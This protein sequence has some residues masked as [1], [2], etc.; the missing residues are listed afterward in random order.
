MSA[1]GE[2]EAKGSGGAESTATITPAQ[3]LDCLAADN[4]DRL[5]TLLASHDGQMFLNNTRFYGFAYVMSS[6]TLLHQ[7]CTLGAVKCIDTLIRLGAD[8]WITSTVFGTAM[9]TGNT[10]MDFCSSPSVQE[11]LVASIQCHLDPLW[12]AFLRND[13]KLPPPGQDM[14]ARMVAAQ[15]VAEDSDEEGDEHD[16][17]GEDGGSDSREEAFAEMIADAIVSDESGTLRQAF[18]GL[19]RPFLNRRFLQTGSFHW[20]AP[21]HSACAKGALNCA[22]TLVELGADP[23]LH[24]IGVWGSSWTAWQWSGGDATMQEAIRAGMAARASRRNIEAATT[25]HGAGDRTGQGSSASGTTSSVGAVALSVGGAT[26]TVSSGSARP[27]PVPVDATETTET[28]QSPTVESTPPP[29]AAAV[30]AGDIA[31]SPAAILDDDKAVAAAAVSQV[32]SH[33]GTRAAPTEC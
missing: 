21:L 33:D 25:N 10:A 3:L 8:P 15:Q 20:Q 22:R 17:G 32:D 19:G 26:A 16:V 24:S 13:P 7:A 14:S 12:V 11:A 5:A 9:T 29:S 27:V 6:V 18:S 4:G 28:A 23:W 2:E 1:P 31:V 30:V